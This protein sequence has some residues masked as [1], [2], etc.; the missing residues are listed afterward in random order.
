METVTAKFSAAQHEPRPAA[1]SA[2]NIIRVAAAL[3][4]SAMMLVAA[5]TAPTFGLVAF[6]TS[7]LLFIAIWEWTD[8]RWP[9]DD[10]HLAWERAVEAQAATLDMVY[11]L[12]DQ[13]AHTGHTPLRLSD[14]KASATTCVCCDL[15][16][17]LDECAEILRTADSRQ[18]TTIDPA[19]LEYLTD[20]AVRL[21]S[22]PAAA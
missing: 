13:I 16:V 7:S 3:G 8:S 10:L 2:R 17:Q 1:L 21:A 14:Y 19:H 11:M 18:F 22:R 12:T 9:T 6:L 15:I 5:E 20:H 4:A